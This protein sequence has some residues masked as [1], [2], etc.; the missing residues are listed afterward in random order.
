MNVTRLLQILE[1]FGATSLLSFGGVNAAVPQLQT[2]AV[3]RYAWM[4]DREFAECFAVA[5]ITP[6]PTTLFVTILGYHAGGM[7]GAV[8]ATLAMAAPACILAFFFSQAWRRSEKALWHAV[9]EK[10]FGP[11][12]VGLL[13]ASGLILAGAVNHRVSDWLITLGA[14]L[15]LSL[16]KVNPLVVICI[17]GF[18]GLVRF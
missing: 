4:S 1:V 10:G 9:L 17:G 7:T 12:G 15:A 13:S 18:A 16:T 5:Q 8:A 2:D 3:D 6:G 14:C 11:V